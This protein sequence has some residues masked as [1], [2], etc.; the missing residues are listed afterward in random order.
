M[1]EVV[2]IELHVVRE[3]VDLDTLPVQVDVQVWIASSDVGYTLHEPGIVIF[4]EC[5]ILHTQSDK[6]GNK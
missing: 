6:V 3:V 1:D 5:V 2:H 4:A